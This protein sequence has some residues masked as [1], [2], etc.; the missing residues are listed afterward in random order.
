[1]LQQTLGRLDGP[2]T[3]EGEN[4]KPALITYWFSK[5]KFSQ[6]VGFID[7]LFMKCIKS[8]V[9]F[10]FLFFF[11]KG[12]NMALPFLLV[13]AATVILIRPETPVTKV[14]NEG[15]LR[16]KTSSCYVLLMSN[17]KSTHASLLT[18]P[19]SELT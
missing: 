3:A 8:C 4:L 5:R 17:S 10:L 13:F 6:Y 9:C 11:S 18:G 14:G 1:M 12:S 15:Y 19:T 16:Q 7:I 2:L